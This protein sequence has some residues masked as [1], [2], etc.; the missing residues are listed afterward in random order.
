MKKESNLRVRFYR[1]KIYR[2]GN[3]STY[4]HTTNGGFMNSDDKSEAVL[5][6]NNS[7]NKRKCECYCDYYNLCDY[8]GIPEEQL[9]E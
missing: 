6:P 3:I 8:C 1:V 4:T 5:Q 7:D 2:Y 9:E